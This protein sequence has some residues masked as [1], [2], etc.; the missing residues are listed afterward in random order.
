M[1]HL[2]ASDCY[3]DGIFLVVSE[4]TTYAARAT[5]EAT[6]WRESSVQQGVVPT[7]PQKFAPQT[8]PP[9]NC[10]PPTAPQI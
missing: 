1:T 3:Q 9:A 6:K 5:I 10:P 8:L 7:A 4:K 2:I